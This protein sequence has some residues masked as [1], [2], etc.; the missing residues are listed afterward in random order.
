MVLRTCM[1]TLRE[2]QLQGSNKERGRKG[3]GRRKGGEEE[4]GRGRKRRRKKGGEGERGGE[5]CTSKGER[6]F[7]GFV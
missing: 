3:R 1:E 7:G 2:N 6:Y 5:I 4:E